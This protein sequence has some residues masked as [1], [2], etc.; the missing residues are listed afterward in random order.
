VVSSSGDVGVAW[1]PARA[2]PASRGVQLSSD[3]GVGSMPAFQLR[4]PA[5]T[6]PALQLR[7]L[8]VTRAFKI[9]RRIVEFVPAVA[10]VPGDIPIRPAPILLFAPD[11]RNLGELGLPCGRNSPRF[12]NRAENGGHK[13]RNTDEVTLLFGR[14]SII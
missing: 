6:M 9:K 8:A 1:V 5:V 11:F 10:L 12:G 4:P 14:P 2:A 7:P 13:S 3:V